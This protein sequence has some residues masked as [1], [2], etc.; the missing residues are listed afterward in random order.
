MEDWNFEK[1]EGSRNQSEKAAS[2]LSGPKRTVVE[3]TIT[4]RIRTIK[5]RH[6]GDGLD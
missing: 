5:L 3:W 2:R 4:T 6:H 1:F